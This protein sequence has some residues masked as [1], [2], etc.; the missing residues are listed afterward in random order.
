MIEPSNEVYVEVI[1]KLNQFLKYQ[2]KRTN[3]L[4]GSAGSGKSWTVAQHLIFRKFLTEHHIRILIVR[5]TCPSLKKSCWLLINDLLRRY[6]VS[7]Y[8]INKSEMIICYKNNEIFFTSIDDPEKL[9]SFERLNYIWAEEATELTKDDFMQLNLRCRGENI[10]GKNEL[11][12]TFNP[13][14]EN[15]FL[16]PL[17]D[18]PPKDYAVC[19]STYLDN[20]FLDKQYVEQLEALQTLDEVYHKIYAL[21]IWATPKGLIYSNWNISDEWPDDYDERIYGLDFGYS[22]SS[23]ALVECRIKGDNLYV[24]EILYE[25]NLTN[26]ELIRRLN[27]LNVSKQVKIIA[28]C[29]EPK[30]IKELN[31]AGFWVLPCD[32]GADSIRHGINAI[33]SFN[34]YITSDS[35][36]IYD[37]IRGYKWREDKFG[38]ALP[39]PVKFKDHALDA[40]RYAVSYIKNSVKAG[41][42]FVDDIKRR[43]EEQTSEDDWLLGVDE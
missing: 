20:P 19:H 9:K 7:H 31:D 36:N 37:E 8:A 11:Y 38:N 16:K 26:P 23:L 14:D 1:P 43:G 27:E 21:G 28:D 33:K 17:C 10:N 25:K 3:L 5:K 4:Y 32:K 34:L 30:S 6:Q 18:N 15:S 24:N 13:T 22:D 29:A 39:E 35:A 41:V 12:F 42:F 40:I 2:T